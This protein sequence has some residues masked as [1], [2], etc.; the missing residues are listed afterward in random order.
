MAL[1]WHDAQLFAAVAEAGNFTAAA[2]R[3]G[4]RQSTVSRRVAELEGKLGAPLFTRGRSGA[5]PTPLGRR[6][7]PAALAMARYA[8][9]FDAL[10]AA[11]GDRLAGTVRI[12]ASPGVASDVLVPFARE[13]SRKH[14]EITM[15]VLS[16]LEILDLSRGQ[17]DLA[18]R[19][20]PPTEKTELSLG[21]AK[22]GIA[23]FAM[24]EYARRL[25]RRPRL[26]DL[27][28]I[29][30]APP[31][32]DVPPTPQIRAAF[33]DYAPTFTSNSFLVQLRALEEGLGAM[34]LPRAIH[35]TGGRASLVELPIELPEVVATVHVVCAKHAR[36][37]PRVRRVGE[38]LVEF[39][40]VLQ[41]RDA[42]SAQ[43]PG[44]R[45]TRR[46]P[47]R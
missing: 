44:A 10:A 46:A 4:V 29:G 22:S 2:A 36:W 47:S 39:L 7:L 42:A 26:E 41:E 27:D 11:K 33:P 23:V 43:R 31:F 9:E 32:E 21:E 14:P 16:D 12:T 30:W 6:L 20:R 3:M 34:V 35:R 40:H 37:L 13:L 38:A 18:V 25:K 19:T 28:F 15:E 8:A 45:P 5:E 17:A 24:P 1:D